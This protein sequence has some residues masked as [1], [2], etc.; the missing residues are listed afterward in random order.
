MSQRAWHRIEWPTAG[1]MLGFAASYSAVVLGHRSL[2]WWLSVPMLAVLG[3]FYMSLQH[4]VLHGHPTPSTGINTALGFA[5]LSLYLPYLRYK[6]LHTQ[7][8]LGELTHPLTDPE[9]FYVDP[10]EWHHAGIWKRLYLQSTRTL[11]GRLTLGSVRAIVGYVMSDLRLASRDRR[12]AAQWLVHLAGAAVVGWWLFGR[13][14]VPVW[15][16]LVGFLGFGYMFTQLRAF[17]EHRAVASGTRSAVVNAGP[18]MSLMYLNNNLHHTHHAAPA[19]PWY[20]LPALHVAM[21]SDALAEAGAGR[22]PGG[23][24][25]VIRRYLVHP[26]CQ[27]PHPL[28]VAGRPAPLPG[29]GE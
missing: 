22:Y 13:I 6:A 1:L 10:Q 7:H 4:E 5:P 2:P 29:S 19:E 20:R 25:E 14:D 24:A 26:F 17:A 9:S 21:G 16:Y 8:H 23:Y 12:V 15:E 27:A 18:V 11:L 3:G 28:M